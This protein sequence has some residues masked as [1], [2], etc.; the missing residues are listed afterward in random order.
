MAA[1]QLLR[2]CAILSAEGLHQCDDVRCRLANTGNSITS[3]LGNPSAHYHLPNSEDQIAVQLH[4]KETR[5]WE[6]S[7]FDI[8]PDFV[9]GHKG[10]IILANDSSLPD[11]TNQSHI[12][13]GRYST[14]LPD[15]RVP[16]PHR[17]VE[18]LVLLLVRDRGTD[19]A[20]YWNSSI[21]YMVQYA[22]TQGTLQKEFLEKPFR[23]Y[24]QSQAT[25][26]VPYR[27]ALDRAQEALGDRAKKGIF[28]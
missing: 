19:A 27:Q 13:G 18:A 9:D 22:L 4:L 1:A 5:F 26:D 15:V 10:S 25:L 8:S 16:T 11:N 3:S 12:G 7:G 14:T 24:I 6:A 28:F 2:A 17:F 20:T 23:D 21:L